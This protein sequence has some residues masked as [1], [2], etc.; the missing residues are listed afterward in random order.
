MYPLEELE[1]GCLLTE[2]GGVLVSKKEAGELER[3]GE[4]THIRKIDRDHLVLD[5]R[6]KLPCGMSYFALNHQVCFWIRVLMLVLKTPCENCLQF[7]WKQV[8]SILNDTHGT[9]DSMGK[10]SK[11][12][13]VYQDHDNIPQGYQ[14]PYQDGTKFTVTMHKRVWIKTLK[15]VPIARRRPSLTGRTTGRSLKKPWCVCLFACM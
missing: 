9:F 3:H 4:A 5:G 12:N 13:Y 7:L 2:Y 15:V 8:G 10:P 6:P 11:V 1:L 14:S